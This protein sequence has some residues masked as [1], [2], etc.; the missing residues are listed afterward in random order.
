MVFHRGVMFVILTSMVVSANQLDH[1]E[2]FEYDVSV[3]GATP[4]GIIT[5]LA[6]ARMN[7][8][9]VLLA[10]SAHIGGMVSGGL[11]RTDI[12]RPSEINNTLLI[13]GIAREFFEL[14]TNWY[15]AAGTHTIYDVEPHVA[16]TLFQRML[17]AENVTVIRNAALSTVSRRRTPGNQVVIE[18]I[19]DDNGREFAASMFVDASYE[20]DLLAKAGVS[21]SLGRESAA[22]FNESLAGFTGGSEP[23]F[24]SCVDPY[25]NQSGSLLPLVDW[26]PPELAVGD[27]DTA[28]S[29]YTFRLC[30]TN[31]ADNRVPF[32]RPARYNR[33]DWELVRRW[34]NGNAQ[35]GPR[36]YRAGK[37]DLNSGG[38]L[39]TDFV[40]TMHGSLPARAWAEANRTTRAMMWQQHKDYVQG[41]IW[42]KGNDPS[43]DPKHRALVMSYGLCKDEFPETGHW[44]PQLYIRESRRMRGERVV[45][46]RDVVS[47]K[48]IGIEAVG[49]GGYVFDT[50]TA[51][52]YACTPGSP[53]G[54][55]AQCTP[56]SGEGSAR[57]CAWD[58]SHMV[59]DPGLFQ[60]PRSLL[61]PQRAEATN[62]AVPTAVSA[63]HVVFSSM[64]ME[65]QWMVLGHAAGVLVAL[66]IK[67]NTA[68]TESGA[69][70]AV[71][72]VSAARLNAVLRE[73]GAMLDLPRPPQI[74]MQASSCVLNRCVPV[75]ST[76]ARARHN[77]QIKCQFCRGLAGN[78]WLAPVAD[79]ATTDHTSASITALRATSLRKSLMPDVATD[80]PVPAGY[81]C[82]RRYLQH[83]RGV[84]ICTVSTPPLSGHKWYAW[85]PMWVLGAHNASIRATATW[86]RAVLKRECAASSSLPPSQVRFFHPNATVALRV[87]PEAVI[88]A[89]DPQYWVVT[90]AG[91]LTD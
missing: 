29:S 47:A 91:N 82:G 8:S 20:G 18:S 17:D 77:K 44:P 89:E 5:A 34:S 64:R 81:S 40:G 21:Y 53:P 79:F 78:E 2:R 56:L 38:P 4:A 83:F 43:I 62:L 86:S 68:Q 32:E 46:Q 57:G 55:N 84:W 72:D 85:K 27:A 13:G 28:V 25:S 66:A 26:L 50:H 33:S 14:V 52:R 1:R 67:D 80:L 76:G 42:F 11:S 41:L 69:A 39:G 59:S 23:Q 48:D 73:Q 36:P 7:C 9:V 75:H 35:W 87:G 30:V 45:T 88:Q 63:S 90:V 24:H 19:Y 37:C 65:P 71:Q 12:I 3:Y 61:L 58:E 16:G 10:E 6:A 60:L 54:R 74:P 15:G 31:S 70:V 49:L 51:R 22:E